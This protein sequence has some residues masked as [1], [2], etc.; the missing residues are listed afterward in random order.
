[1]VRTLVWRG[2]LAMIAAVAGTCLFWPDGLL[3]AAIPIWLAFPFVV[4]SVGLFLILEGIGS[5]RI[6]KLGGFLF[7]ALLVTGAGL[8]WIHALRGSPDAADEVLADLLRYYAVGLGCALA[9]LLLG[10]TRQARVPDG[11]PNASG[12]PPSDE[13]IVLVSY[14]R[15]AWLVLIAASGYN[16]WSHL[17]VSFFEPPGCGGF[18]L[19]VVTL[20]TGLGIGTVILVET[21]W[22]EY[23][24]V[25]RG[26]AVS[27]TGIVTRI[28]SV[29]FLLSAMLLME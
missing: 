13:T 2:F 29:V 10:D 27:W 19:T 7:P 5:R 9:S 21:A 8:C 6:V 3:G 4:P 11:P 28:L 1:M 25:T 15:A 22:T 26:I 18:A 14:N 20:W 24:R 12:S 23:R 17:V 16:V